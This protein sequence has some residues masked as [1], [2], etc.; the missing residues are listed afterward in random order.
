VTAWCAVMAI[1]MLVFGLIMGAVMQLSGGS[2]SVILDGSAVALITVCLIIAD[3]LPF[4]FFAS[5]GRGYMLPMGLAV[6][7]LM[8]ANIMMVVGRA[9]YFPW[10]IPILFAQGESS[11]TLISYW[12]VIATSVAGM[13]ATY[14][15]WKYADQN[16]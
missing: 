7:T 6:L 4:A 10:A 8:M 5:V 9:E 14:V 13:V 2:M 11:L 1:L 12:I 16:R 3:V 15:W